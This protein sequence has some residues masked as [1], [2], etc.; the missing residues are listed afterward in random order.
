MKSKNDSIKQV[1]QKSKKNKKVYCRTCKAHGIIVLKA[2][3]K[4]YCKTL[5]CLCKMCSEIKESQAQSALN[6]KKSRARKEDENKNKIHPGEV[7]L[8]LFVKSQIS[9]FVIMIVKNR[10]ALVEKTKYV[11]VCKIFIYHYLNFFKTLRNIV[12][13]VFI[14]KMYYLRLR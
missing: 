11:C 13:N 1:D 2:G 8:F 6:I 10:S 7:N 9:N 5:N 14:V 3:H 4:R 12:Y